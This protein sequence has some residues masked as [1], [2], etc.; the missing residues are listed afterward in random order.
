MK[1]ILKKSLILDTLAK[2]QGIAGKKT[3]HA[4]ISCVMIKA[5]EN[6]FKLY[7]T[8][9]EN[10]FIGFYPSEIETEGEIA[11]NARK[12]YEI[13]RDFP[14]EDILINEVD[15]F[16]IEIG[17]HSVQYHLV[18]MN[19]D[20]FPKVPEIENISFIEVDS[21]SFKKM[22]DKTSMIAASPED[23][24][25]HVLG[26]CLETVKIENENWIRIIS[27]DGNRLAK[28]DYPCTNES[29]LTLDRSVLIQ[30][31]GFNELSKIIIPE[32]KLFIGI[33][34]NKLFIK[35]QQE[36]I[37]IQLLNG[38]FPDYMDIISK[39][40]GKQIILNKA[41]FTMMLKRMSIFSTEDYKGVIFNFNDDRMIVTSTNPE[42]GESKEE[43]FIEYS[44]EPV[45]V[46]F[47]PR[48]FIESLSAI[49]D[50]KIIMNITDEE[51][52]CLVEGETEK[53]Y[54]CVIMP[55]KI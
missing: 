6:G 24:R 30:K 36:I 5:L 45:E 38:K 20:S 11:V 3:S 10:G 27:T 41:M 51:T 2:I 43:M 28:V 4:I 15:N 40:N 13:V 16:W 25:P 35:Q 12:L 37:S 47:N 1:F 44:A 19:P 21:R 17:N 50:E 48:Y 54:Q 34:E 49:E 39:S 31:K 23:K 52:P 29:E 53:S 32:G 7:V 46:S 33:M 9:Y 26:I 8:D 55:M 22:I 18:G 42:L 14:T